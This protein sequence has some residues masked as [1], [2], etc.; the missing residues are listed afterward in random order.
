MSDYTRKQE[1]AN[2]VTHAAGILFGAV[3]VPVLLHDAVKNQTPAIQLTALA[4]YGFS[5]L[6]V[7]STSTIYHSITKP[8]LK[9]L[10]RSI[11]HIA[12]FFLIAGSATPIVVR[13]VPTET[14][15]MFLV[16]QW[17]LVL[18]GTI[19]KL[20]FTG[21]FRLVS[22]FIYIAMGMLPI[23]IGAPLFN[24][25]PPEVYVAVIVGGVFYITGAYFY[26]S[27]KLTYSHAIWHVFV[28]G[29]SIAH[30]AAIGNTI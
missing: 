9:K 5:L 4:I 1:I 7:F 15:K 23:V 18:G 22:T 16:I 30:F 24:A 26:M 2:I 21:R 27:K 12:I 8:K 3:A 13:Y 14:A 25:L 19:F 10:W 17:S 6:L 11:D 28:L 29:G 20:F